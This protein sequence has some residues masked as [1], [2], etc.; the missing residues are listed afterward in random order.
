M[1]AHG[2]DAAT[3]RSSCLRPSHIAQD[4]AGGTIAEQCGRNE[5][6]HA[7]IGNAKAKAAKVHSQK[8]YMGAGHGLGV[9]RRPAEPGNA[10]PTTKSEDRYPLHRRRQ[11]QP[12]HQ[13]GVKARDGETRDRVHHESANVLETNAGGSDCRQRHLLEQLKRVT[14][15]DLGARF[16]AVAL[17][18]PFL[19]LTGVAVADA[20]IGIKGAETGKMREHMLGAFGDVVLGDFVRRHGRRHAGDLDV[21]SRCPLA[22]LLSPGGGLEH[23]AP[24]SPS[25]A[26]GHYGP[27]AWRQARGPIGAHPQF[28][29]WRSGFN[30]PQT[31]QM[32]LSP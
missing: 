19:R 11:F 27:Q 12:V 26:V 29:V 2:E 21:E 17:V 10:A 28:F 25:P 6:R 16:P 23:P 32:G 9:T 20:G 22:R 3:P 14:L 31:R 15:E 4:D 13:L 1:I 24:T 18:I 30:S 8:Q 7:R 5:H